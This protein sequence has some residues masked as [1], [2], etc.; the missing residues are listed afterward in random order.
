MSKA[1][2]EPSAQSSTGLKLQTWAWAAGEMVAHLGLGT[3]RFA[4]RDVSLAARP[5]ATAHSLTNE[6]VLQMFEKYGPSLATWLLKTL[7]PALDTLKN[8]TN[9][10]SS[11][12]TN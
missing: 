7:I 5:L 6:R 1:G 10:F 9:I 8:T 4:T 11:S 2:Y 12:K 3:A